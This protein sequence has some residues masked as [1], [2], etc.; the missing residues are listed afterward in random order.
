MDENKALKKNGGSMSATAVPAKAESLPQKRDFKAM[1]A[2]K[3]A[4]TERN[5]EDFNQKFLTDLQGQIDDMFTKVEEKRGA[6]G[7]LFDD[8]ESPAQEAE[9][10]GS[11]VKTAELSAEANAE[12]AQVEGKEKIMDEVRKHA[13]AMQTDIKDLL[14]NEWAGTIKSLES[15]KE[16]AEDD[17]KNNLAKAK[18]DTKAIQEIEKQHQAKMT[19]LNSQVFKLEKEK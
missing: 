8:P 19:N 9:G 10:D 6:Q 5:I 2:N 16:K 17:K 7:K 11:D 15:E 18:N 4:S 12:Q 1:R 14:K 3:K 13:L